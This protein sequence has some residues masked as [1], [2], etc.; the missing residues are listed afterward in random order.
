ML[1]RMD[2]GATG[3]TVLL[4][5]GVPTAWMPVAQLVLRGF[6]SP[7]LTAGD[8]NRAVRMGQGFVDLPMTSDVAERVAVTLVENGVEA[9][10]LKWSECEPAG[11]PLRVPR[12]D[13]AGPEVTP[14]LPW[15]RV[16]VVHL[17]LAESAPFFLPPEVNSTTRSAGR[18]ASGVSLGARALGLDT[19]GDAAGFV[20]NAADVLDQPISPTQGPPQVIVELLGLWAPRVHL[21]V[22][23]F[24]H[25]SVPGPPANGSRAR[26]AKLL[27]ALLARAAGA[28]RV[29]W[30][31]QA[32][33]RA[34]VEPKPLPASE[35]KRL[36]SAWLTARRVWPTD[37]GGA[38]TP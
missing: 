17:V 26:L 16:H 13:F 27:S 25:D 10:A 21:A 34:A 24:Q 33:A 6:A 29:G 32:L 22:D 8:V 9:R 28:R 14:G 23:T 1:G 3:W 35:H 12:V 18:I 5:D 7:R 36:V 30:I 15:D 38:S 19:V 11:V 2:E 20:S 37:V 4:R 31:E